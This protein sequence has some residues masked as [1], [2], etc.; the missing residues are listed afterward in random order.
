MWKKLLQ[1]FPGGTKENYEN[2]SQDS[3]H[4]G[5]ESDLKYKAGLITTEVAHL[6]KIVKKQIT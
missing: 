2:L 6:M 5:W 3:W 4:V 1:N